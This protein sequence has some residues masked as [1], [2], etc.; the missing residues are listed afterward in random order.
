[1]VE[2]T[3]KRYGRLDIFWHNAGPG[4]PRGFEDTN[5]A[6]YDEFMNIHLKGGFFGIQAAIP[7]LRKTGGGS[8]L[9]TA[10]ISGLKA[11]SPSAAYACAKAALVN[12]TKWLAAYYAKDNIRVNCLCPGVIRTGAWQIAE[13][14]T[15]V[16]EMFDDMMTAT[17]MNRAGTSEEVAASALFLVSADASYITGETLCVDGGSYAYARPRTGSL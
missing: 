15:A 11:W 3:V 13:R 6:E 8:I 9:I 5:E 14:D 10:S 4:G 7:Q 12:L 1:M 2:E 17:P 16:Q